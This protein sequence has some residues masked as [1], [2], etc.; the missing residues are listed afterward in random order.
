MKKYVDTLKFNEGSQFNLYDKD[1]NDTGTVVTLLHINR[2]S[3]GFT[4]NTVDLEYSR[5]NEVAATSTM[6]EAQFVDYV[7]SGAFRKIGG[8]K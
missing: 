1:N 2:Y 5:H 4:E 6:T 7:T 3:D 8:Y